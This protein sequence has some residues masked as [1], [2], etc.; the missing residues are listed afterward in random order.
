MTLTVTD[1]QGASGTATRSAVATAPPNDPFA[2]DAFARTIAA[3][4]GTADRGA[5]WSLTGVTSKYSVTAGG[6]V[7]DGEGRGD[8]RRGA[9]GGV[10]Q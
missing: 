2:A 8:G 9:A 5:A 4:W 6:R 1:N 3:G 7:D 10:F